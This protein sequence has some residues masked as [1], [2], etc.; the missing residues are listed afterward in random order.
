MSGI[1][2][3]LKAIKN[4]ILLEER[5]S[6]QSR[7]LEQLAENVV[8]MD[9][10]LTL[11]EGRMDGFFSAATAFGAGARR[12]AKSIAAAPIEMPPGKES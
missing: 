10:R 6:S 8:E 12:S 7:K 3:A 5:I 11:L 2:D 4:A 9:K 1:S